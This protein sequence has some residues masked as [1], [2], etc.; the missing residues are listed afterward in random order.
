MWYLLL[1]AVL[2]ALVVENILMRQKLD[3]A[4]V[5]VHQAMFIAEKSNNTSAECIA[6]LDD[7]RNRL[8]LAVEDVKSNPFTPMWGPTHQKTASVLFGSQ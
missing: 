6:T 8:R 3:A 2:A 1:G 5:M 7:V 4:N